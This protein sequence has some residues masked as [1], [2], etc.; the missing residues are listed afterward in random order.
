MPIDLMSPL[1]AIESATMKLVAK[2]ESEKHLEVAKQN[3]ESKH[4][5]AEAYKKHIDNQLNSEQKLELAKIEKNKANANARKAKYESLKYQYDN[6]K[7]AGD[8]AEQN[9]KNQQE[10]IRNSQVRLGGDE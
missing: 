4:I 5:T 1:Q 9:L 7:D 2:Q 6:S 10:A 3:A 8:I